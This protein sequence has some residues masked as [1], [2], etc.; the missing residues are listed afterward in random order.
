MYRDCQFDVEQCKDKDGLT[1]VFASEPVQ[2][3]MYSRYWVSSGM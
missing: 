2:R 3:L 1:S